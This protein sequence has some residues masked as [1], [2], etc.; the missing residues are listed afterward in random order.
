MPGLE[1]FPSRARLNAL[2]QLLHC[3]WV[4]DTDGVV[5]MRSP[6]VL[7]LGKLCG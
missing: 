7:G 5:V 2:G 6:N 3:F 4:G 1:H